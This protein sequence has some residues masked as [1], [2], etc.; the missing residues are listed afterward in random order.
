MGVAAF[1]RHLDEKELHELRASRDCMPELAHACTR[2]QHRPYHRRRNACT[3]ALAALQQRA[4]AIAYVDGE[5]VHYSHTRA[6]VTTLEGVRS[7]SVLRTVARCCSA[8]RAAKMCGAERFRMRLCSWRRG[9]TI[10]R[11]CDT[12]PRDRCLRACPSRCSAV[13]CSARL[14]TSVWRW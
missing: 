11:S 3:A 8:D 2:L 1:V 14:P 12:P 4:H 13:Q 6:I 7:P 9:R 10:L 5:A